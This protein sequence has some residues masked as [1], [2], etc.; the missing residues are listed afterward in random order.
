[1]AATPSLAVLR[2]L[3][4]TSSWHEYPARRFAKSVQ[5]QHYTDAA[6]F[7]KAIRAIGILQQV[8]M[9]FRLASSLGGRQCMSL[10]TDSPPRP[11]APVSVKV[12]VP[13][14]FLGI[15]LAPPKPPP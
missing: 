2:V 14:I 1:M 10:P 13:L 9:G 4:F 3:S 11:S 7:S 12:S 5:S 8:R 15:L 6:I